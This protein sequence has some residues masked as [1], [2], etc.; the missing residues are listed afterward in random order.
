MT[1]V[2][3]PASVRQIALGQF[4]QNAAGKTIPQ[5]TTST[6][7]T[8]ANGRILIT[9][10][11]GVV[12]TVVGGTTPPIKLI[13][14]PTVGTLNDMCAAL[15]VTASEVGTQFALPGPVGT[16]LIGTISK[17]GSVGGQTS[18]QIVAAGTIGLNCSAA[19]A[20]GAIKWTLTYV[21]LD[22]GATVTAA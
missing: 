19:D 9:S 17:S 21:A 18:Q 7:F 16:A 22:N 15:T 10:L 1:T 8:V 5:N 12:T 20:T 11:T 3:T 14:T 2:L 6:I 4:A 13:A